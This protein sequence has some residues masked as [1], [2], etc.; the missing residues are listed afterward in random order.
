MSLYLNNMEKEIFSQTLIQP[1]DINEKTTT[2]IIEDLRN[3]EL[4]I[5]K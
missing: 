1:F 2:P 5:S 4:H 3:I